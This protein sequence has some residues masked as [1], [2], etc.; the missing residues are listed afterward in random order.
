ML[1]RKV[2][3]IE[4]VERRVVHATDVH[5]RDPGIAQL[6]IARIASDDGRTVDRYEYANGQ[7]IVLMGAAGMSQD[8]VHH[9]RKL[10]RSRR[11]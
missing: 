9:G 5:D 4:T 10:T 1:A 7:Q 2:V 6:R 3:V 8:R 11:E